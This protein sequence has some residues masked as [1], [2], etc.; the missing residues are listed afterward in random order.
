[1]LR[2][3]C[4]VLRGAGRRRVLSCDLT[5]H[6]ESRAVHNSGL[7]TQHSGRRRPRIKVENGRRSTGV[8]ARADAAGLP[9]TWS[10]AAADA[11]WASGA[12]GS[13]VGQM[14]ERRPKRCAHEESPVMR[15]P[16]AS[17]PSKRLSVVRDPPS[18]KRCRSERRADLSACRSNPAGD[19]TRGRVVGGAD[20]MSRGAGW[21]VTVRVGDA[22]AGTASECSGCSASAGS[23]A[24]GATRMRASCPKTT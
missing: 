11:A 5:I 17:S 6:G 3:G 1:M 13:D 9:T 18:S 14:T 12:A 21:F 4:W 15:S 19:S 10:R 2:A 23:R 22:V 7:S 16:A 24:A 20:A 8:R